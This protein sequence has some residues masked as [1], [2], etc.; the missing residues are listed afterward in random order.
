MERNNMIFIVSFLN[1]I[2]EKNMKGQV[3]GQ[4]TVR[5]TTNF[6]WPGG[7]YLP[8]GPRRALAISIIPI[9]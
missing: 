3:R 2:Q 6:W 4:G 7:F 1:C 5:Q 8:H 9:I